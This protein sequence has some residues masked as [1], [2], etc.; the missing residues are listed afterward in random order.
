MKSYGQ[1][2]SFARS[3]D[4][5]GERWTL[6]VVR[7]LL[8]GSTRFGDLRRGIPRVSRTMLSARLR[9]L[10]DAGVV[11]RSG[12]D[13]GP[14]YALTRSGEELAAVVRELGTW[15][16]RWLPRTLPREEL[17][18]DVLLW[19]IRRRVR[20]E[21]LPAEPVVAVVEVVEASGRTRARYLLLRRSEV[22][23]CSANQGFPEVLRVRASLR[24]LTAWWR[25]DISLAEAR[26]E[27]MSIQG[28][29]EWV[30]A[31][32]RWFER[33]VFADV[34]PVAAKR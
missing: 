8:N 20:A 1:F 33:Y 7:E 17:D 6:L 21:E 27:G 25:G 18:E 12:G 30:R 23:L 13:D 31:F 19:D 28:S 14:A 29:R 4:L 16:Q 15:G 32:P 3:L 9:E 5:L 11:A 34:S 26:A 10:C 22:S 24:T 2:C